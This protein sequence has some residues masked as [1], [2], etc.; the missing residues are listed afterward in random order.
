LLYILD[1]L[2][3]RFTRSLI[4][5][6]TVPLKAVLRYAASALGKART[7]VLNSTK[8]RMVQLSTTRD[9]IAA[10]AIKVRSASVSTINR[11]ATVKTVQPRNALTK[12]INRTTLTSSQ[13]RMLILK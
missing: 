11:N 9:R 2:H 10:V 8:S 5:S 7:A 4:P 12:T 13:N 6:H 1:F 3:E